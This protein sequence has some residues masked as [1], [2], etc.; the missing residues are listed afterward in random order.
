MAKQVRLFVTD[1]LIKSIKNNINEIED[2]V[3]I[4]NIKNRKAI[5]I[6][7]YSLLEGAVFEYLR[8][9]LYAFTEKIGEKNYIINKEDLNGSEIKETIVKKYIQN[10]SRAN[11][12]EYILKACE[13]VDIESSWLKDNK[14]PLHEAIEIRNII[15]HNNMNMI[16]TN[17]GSEQG[18]LPHDDLSVEYITKFAKKCVEILNKICLLFSSKYSKYTKE[19]LLREAW[20]YVFTSPILGFDSIWDMNNKL[21]LHIKGDEA[22]HYVKS[23]SSSEKLLLSIWFNQYST[24]L[25]KRFFDFNEMPMLVSV[26]SSSKNQI[27]FL[28]NL[29]EQYPYLLNGDLQRSFS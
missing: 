4:L 5:F 17:T 12:Y 11:L 2:M 10:I 9:Y 16:K 18:E 1:D 28:I 3:T 21:G 23:A 24:S 26:D 22:E 27:R 14:L 6:Y 19:Y 25:N 13:L 7:I 20:K 15:T 29:F 8:S